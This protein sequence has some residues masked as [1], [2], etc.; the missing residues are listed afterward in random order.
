MTT[1]TRAGRA[2]LDAT[3]AVV[4]GKAAEIQRAWRQGLDRGG[5]QASYVAR[6]APVLVAAIKAG[7]TETAA[8]AP[9][10]VAGVLGVEPP[11]QATPTVVP[12]AF[13]G[14]TTTG[15][16]LA[17]LADLL[18]I[19]LLADLGAGMSATDAMLIGLRRALTY[20]ATEITDAGRTAT[21]VQLIADRRA[22]GYERVVKLPA[23]DRCII[24]A[25]R[26]YRVSQGF[27]RHPRCDCHMAPVTR[28]QWRESNPDHHPRA[29]FESMSEAEQ[30]TRFGTGNAAAI[31]AGA[32]PAQV[33]NA[34]RAA[35]PV[36]GRW[37]TTQ[38]TT[39]RGLVGQRL[40]ELATWPG[41]R[42][43]RS[44]L[45]RPTAGQLVAD[46]S[47]RPREELIAALRRYGYLL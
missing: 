8:L 3:Q 37:T 5:L 32:D 12:A 24:L 35:M 44:R 6:V 41:H 31:R 16:P 45:A 38:G 17:G 40:G 33:V 13:A 27:R 30:N 14:F 36:A 23:C 4:R 18:I 2:H 1:P 22:A 47:G 28:E 11:E 46:L 15:L 29:L 39:S 26:L 9:S 7:Q 19:R 10:Y 42:Y 20:T 21:Q 25:G 43:Q 34:R